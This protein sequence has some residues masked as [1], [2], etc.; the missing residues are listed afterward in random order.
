M[1]SPEFKVEYERVAHAS[2]RPWWRRTTLTLVNTPG[3][4]GR[5]RVPAVSIAVVHN[6]EIE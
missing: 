2:P 3:P 6:G 4:H 5:D 1:L